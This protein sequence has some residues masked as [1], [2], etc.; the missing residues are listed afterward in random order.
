MDYALLEK[1]QI[2]EFLK[3]LEELPNVRATLRSEQPRVG[4]MEFDALIDLTIAGKSCLL[5]V[6]VKKSAYPRD[7]RQAIWQLR[8]ASQALKLPDKTTSLVFLSEYL[9]PGAKKLLEAEKIGYFDSGGSLYLSTQGAYLYIEKPPAK[10]IEKSIRSFFS[11][12]RSQILHALLIHPIRWFGVH[13]LAELAMVSPATA[14]EVLSELED[15]D[16]LISR[17]RGPRKERQLSQPAALLD[18]WSKQVKTVPGP[19]LTRYY[20]PGTKFDRLLI[21]IGEEFGRTNTEY[22]ITYEAAAQMY[23]PFLSSIAQVRMRLANTQESQAALSDL[24]ARSVT[25]GSNLAIIDAESKGDFL[26]RTLLDNIWLASPVQ[27]Y[28]DLQRGEG[29]STELAK[30]LRQEKIGF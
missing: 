4:R 6:E 13:E 8:A 29:R 14:S 1:R 30:H 16:W 20:V 24:G 25:E 18:E 28:L 9:S 19:S 23:A 26:F 27:V 3:T 12:R 21:R 15:M 5:V 17:G 2:E 11:G 10:A 22:A 7:V